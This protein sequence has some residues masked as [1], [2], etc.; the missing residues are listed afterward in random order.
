MNSWLTL[1]RDDVR[2]VALDY[3][4]SGQGA[5]LLHGLAGHAG[6]WKNT[7]EWLTAGHRVLAP[8]ARGHGRSDI[9]P[10][11]VSRAAH[12]NDVVFLIE[13]LTTPPVILIGQSLGG[14]TALLVAA[15]RPD[16]IRVLVL[17]DAGPAGAGSERA[18]QQAASELGEA[19]TRW[20]VPFQSRN[21]AVSFFGGPSVAAEAW[22]D[23]LVE[24]DRGLS[25]A[26]EIPVMVETLRQAVARSYWD[27][28]KSIRCPTLIVRAEHGVV[29]EGELEM[30]VDSLPHAEVVQL[31][32]AGHD[33]HLHEPEQWQTAVMTFLGSQ[34]E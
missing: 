33:L 12:V 13:E 24:D 2:L 22:V 3:G 20:P 34:S 30:M 29:D 16:L 19:L 10:R 15:R 21:S 23:G 26:F 28:W 7:S 1:H 8:D 14:H 32:G 25:S 27:E 17:A 18:A 9:H 31:P 5:V 6:E 11:D 4:G